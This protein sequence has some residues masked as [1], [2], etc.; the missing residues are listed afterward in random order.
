MP[1]TESNNPDLHHGVGVRQPGGAAQPGRRA[2]GA[3]GVQLLHR[4]GH[5]GGGG[6]AAAARARGADG[7]VARPAHL[8][9]PAPQVSSAGRHQSINILYFTPS[10]LFVLLG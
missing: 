6:G 7:G 3:D 9:P 4:P 8:P 1:A 2:G 10:L 5:G